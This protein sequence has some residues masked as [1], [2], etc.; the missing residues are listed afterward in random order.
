MAYVHRTVDFTCVRTLRACCVHKRP[1]ITSHSRFHLTFE[2]C[3]RVACIR[4]RVCTSYSRL[5][6]RVRTLRACCVREAAC[7]HRTVDFTCVRT[8][9]TCCVREAACV[10]SISLAFEHCARVACIRGRVCTSYS[11]FHLRSNIAR[12]LRA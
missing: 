1:R 11:R 10:Q 9:R 5:A 8:L 6:L 4:G 2:H 7:V 12:V 3:A